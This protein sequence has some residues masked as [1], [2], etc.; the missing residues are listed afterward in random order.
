VPSGRADGT[1][2]AVPPGEITAQQAT[3]AIG[4]ALEDAQAGDISQVQVL[5]GLPQGEILQTVL[6]GRDA[7]IGDLE[8]RVAR[9]EAAING[10]EPSQSRLPGLPLIL[11]GLAVVAAVVARGRSPDRRRDPSVSRADWCKSRRATTIP[12]LDRLPAQP[13]DL[14]RPQ[15]NRG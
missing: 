10:A 11:G 5:V 1:G 8:G 15:G 13:S 6:E 7:R 14:T 3:Q 2:V 12:H 4:R 9:L